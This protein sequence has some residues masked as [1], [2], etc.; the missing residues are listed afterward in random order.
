MLSPLTP[1]PREPLTHPF[2]WKSLGALLWAFQFSPPSI[3]ICPASTQRPWHPPLLP[4]WPQACSEEQPPFAQIRRWRQLLSISHSDRFNPKPV[5]LSP[6]L[7]L[8]WVRSHTVPQTYLSTLSR[9]G[10]S[11]GCRGS[12]DL[13]PGTWHMSF[14][15]CALISRPQLS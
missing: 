13:G 12:S 7:C 14:S 2:R 3:T 11:L 6:R 10:C 8:D 15:L 4:R 9:P 5:L 1:A